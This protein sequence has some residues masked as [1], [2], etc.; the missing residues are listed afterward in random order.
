MTVAA[1]LVTGAAGGIGRVI[2][3]RLAASSYAVLAADLPVAFPGPTSGDGGGAGQV[4]R[5]P[6]DVR[7]TESVEKAVAAAAALG[8]LRAVVNCAGVLR[9]HRVTETGDEDLEQS[10]Q[11]NLAGAV[12]ICRAATPFLPRGGAIVTIGSIAAARGGAPGV[13]VY[14][15]SKAGLEGF[16]RAL[17]S[18]LGP[19]GIRVNVVAP[20]FVRA[21]MSSGLRNS[22]GD[23]RL[24]RQVP[25][26]RLAE[27]EEVAEVVEFLL[28]ERA[29]YVSGV[30]LPVDGGTTAR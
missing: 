29:S 30:V 7:S 15:A 9:A 27:P 11:V 21:P 17:A 6:L 14:A 22:A 24:A 2:A 10:L 20:G 12:R 25:L 1:A 13:A 16:T 18:E 19:A 3:D 8:T 23:E 5:F 4:R 26:G 28:S